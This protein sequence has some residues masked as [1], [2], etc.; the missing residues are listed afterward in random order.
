LTRVCQ[1]ILFTNTSNGE[2]VTLLIKIGLKLDQK[3]VLYPC[4][5]KNVMVVSRN[6]EKLS[7]LYHI[8]L[9]D[10]HIVEMLMD[11]VQFYKYAQQNGFP[12]PRTFFIE[13]H[14]DAKMAAQELNFPCV[15]KPAHRTSEWEQNTTL[16]AFKVENVESFWEVYDR[17]HQWTKFFIAQEWIEGDDQTLYSC[18]C[19]FNK[20]GKPVATFIARK[21]RQWPPRTG[22]SSLGV[23]CKSPEVL[24]EC[25]RL[26]KKVNFK[27]LGYIEFKKD[28]RTGKYFIIEP[29]IGRPTGR[30]AIA[31][32]GGVDLLYAMYCD[33][34][35]RELP[36]NLQ[37]KYIGVKWIH[38]RRDFQSALYYWRNGE[39]SIK[40][41]I[42]S[43]KGPKAF[44]VFSTSDPLPFLGDIY[45][46]IK[47]YL[48]PSE[49]QK[50]TPQIPSA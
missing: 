29:N 46:S 8:V 50:R 15:M 24:N 39:L 38:L 26:F 11:K 14:R 32:A 22:Q 28:V 30:S 44:A 42:R 43:W 10:K 23:E 2:L 1:Q 33:V 31:E 49:R 25:L 35:N 17:Y 9:P 7:R 6:R 36:K 41:W 19:Y 18:N 40:D 47:L 37:Q 20:E 34:L 21:I 48:S 12:I 16:K 5:D 27:G 45:R 13:N 3:A 4:E